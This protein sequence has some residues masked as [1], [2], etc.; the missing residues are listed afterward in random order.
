MVFFTS[1]MGAICANNPTEMANV[2]RVNITFF[3]VTFFC[4]TYITKIL[5]KVAIGA[6]VMQENAEINT[7]YN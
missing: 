7:F 5:A 6:K 1:E 2:L 4:S 3:I